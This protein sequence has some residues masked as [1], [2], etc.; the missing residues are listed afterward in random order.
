M[1]TDIRCRVTPRTAGARSSATERRD[2]RHQSKA[3]ANCPLGH[4]RPFHGLNPQESARN[5]GYRT[6]GALR[7]GAANRVLEYTY[8]YL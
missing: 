8:K 7:E 1:A 5:H 6:S 2:T 3:Y 4:E